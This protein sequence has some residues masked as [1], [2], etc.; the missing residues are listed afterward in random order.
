MWAGWRAFDV[1]SGVDGLASLWMGVCHQGKQITRFPSSQVR[2]QEERQRPRN[3]RWLS[4]SQGAAHRDEKNHRWDSTCRPRLIHY[5]S[6]SITHHK[7]WE[8]DM[9]QYSMCEGGVEI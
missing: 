7:A 3:F 9:S 6:C 2:P 4:A 5:S 1:D 8:L